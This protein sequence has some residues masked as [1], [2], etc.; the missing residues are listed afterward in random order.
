[1]STTEL[2]LFTQA[3]AHLRMT[4]T[5]ERESMSIQQPYIYTTTSRSSGHLP[6]RAGCSMLYSQATSLRI[7]QKL[8]DYPAMASRDVTASKGMMH[9]ILYCELG[10][11]V[12]AHRWSRQMVVTHYLIPSISTA[13]KYNSSYRSPPIPHAH[14]R[15]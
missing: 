7:D 10:S 3:E 13:V 6:V 12:N 15:P 11:K 2:Q 9:S 8:L 14:P 4:T 5:T 1:M